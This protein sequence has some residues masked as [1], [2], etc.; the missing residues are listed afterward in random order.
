MSDIKILVMDVDGTLTDGKI[1]MGQD[2][3]CFKAFDI[4]D[5]AGIALLLPEYNIIPVIITA[6]ESRILENRCKELKI[7]ELHQGCFYKL[8]KLREIIARYNV[9]LDAVAYIGDDLPDI[10]CMEAIRKAGGVVL[11]P[12]DAIPEIKELSDYV[13]GCKAGNGSIRDCINYVIQRDSHEDIIK[14]INHVIEL[15]L[16]GEYTDQPVGMLSDGTHYTIQEYETKDEKECVIETHRYHVDVQYIISGREQLELFS[17][18][19]LTSTGRYELETDSEFWYG[20][21]SISRTILTQGSLI[22]V[23]NNQPHKGA[24]RIEDSERVRKLVCKI[25]L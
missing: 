4:K 15:V 5:G 10:P 16:N 12:S 22:V 24:I 11:C 25:A 2:G 19:C 8:E 7:T 3:E 20:G 17:N 23:M 21:V 6:R 14:R 18:N 1:Y 9:G 13:S